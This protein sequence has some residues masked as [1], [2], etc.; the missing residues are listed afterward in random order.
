MKIHQV[1]LG[2][3]YQYILYSSV[4]NHFIYILYSSVFYSKPHPLF[5]SS[6]SFTHQNAQFHHLLLFFFSFSFFILLISLSFFFFFFILCLYNSSWML[7]RMIQHVLLIHDI[8]MMTSLSFVF[9]LFFSF[10]FKIH[11]RSREI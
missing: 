2:S 5:V 6:P 1:A 7:V 10:F 4:F 3:V 11:N 8:M 9:C